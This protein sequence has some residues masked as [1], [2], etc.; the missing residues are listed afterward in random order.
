[1]A[2]IVA[3]D[4]RD[5]LEGFSITQ[6]IVSDARIL[7]WLNGN[8]IPFVENTTK[9]SLQ[10]VKTEPAE[11]HIGNGSKQL[12]LDRRPIID[13]VSIQIVPLL[14]AT[15]ILGLDSFINIADEGIVRI[16]S[17]LSGSYSVFAYFPRGENVEVSY[18]YGWASISA[19]PTDLRQALIDM[20][21]VHVLRHLAGQTGGGNLSVQGFSRDYGLKGKYTDMR[22]SLSNS[23]LA[24]LKKYSSTVIGS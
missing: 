1:M 15:F 3:Q 24:V 16:K 23:A 19:L 20:T 2:D 14:G 17:T 21:S 13:L 5:N 11:Y 6:S 8:V 7:Q 10:A 4:I 12:I 18:T 9:Q 22:T